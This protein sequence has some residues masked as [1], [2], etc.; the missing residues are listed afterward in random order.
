MNT[1]FKKPILYMLVG[2][3]GSGKTTW[4][5]SQSWFSDCAYISTDKFV[6]QYAIEK[7]KTYNEVFH[8]Y[9]PTAINLMVDEVAEARYDRKDII[10]DQTSTTIASRRRK[11]NLL[12]GYNAI[13]VVFKTPAVDEL[14]KRLSNRPGKEIPWNIVE[15]MINGWEEPN[16]VEGFKE[17]WIAT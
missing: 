6:E 9:M 17:I 11:F 13:A 2:V 5:T 3:P 8:D 12:P 1:E 15:N 10:W 4:A 16:V 14:A 7:G